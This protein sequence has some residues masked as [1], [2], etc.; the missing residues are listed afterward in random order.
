MD[1]KYGHPCFGRRDGG[2]RRSLWPTLPA[3]SM[4]CEIFCFAKFSFSPIPEFLIPPKRLAIFI[5]DF[6]SVYTDAIFIGFRQ[7]KCRLFQ[8]F[9]Q[10]QDPQDGFRVPDHP[11]ESAVLLRFSPKHW[12]RSV[13]GS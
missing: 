7:S 9:S 2:P 10:V 4:D 12:P 8:F 3:S 5:P 13:S 1:F 6:A 11:S